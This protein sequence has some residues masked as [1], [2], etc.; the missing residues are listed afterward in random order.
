MIGQATVCRITVIAE[1]ERERGSVHS[2]ERK[3]PQ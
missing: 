2:R 3:C 1:R